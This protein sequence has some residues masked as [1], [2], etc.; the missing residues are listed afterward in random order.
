MSTLTNPMFA[1]NL[2][3]AMLP[4]LWRRRMRLSEDEMVSMYGL[5]QHALHAYHPPELHALREDK[6]ELVAQF[7]YSK[8]L[9]LE[10]DRADSHARP[11]SAPSTIYAICAYFRRYLIDCLRS[12]VHQRHVSIE[13]EGIEQEVNMHAH[14]VEDPIEFVLMQYALDES[15]VR[16]AAAA[17]IAGLDD[18][19]RV[20][21]GGSLGWCSGRKGG[22]SGVAAMHRVSSHHYRAVKLG[23]T[24]RKTATSADF[25]QSKIGR[26]LSDKLGIAISVDNRAAILIVLNLLAE[27]SNEVTSR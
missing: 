10:P 8:V 20:I 9:R 7:I 15:R 12:A 4:D 3:V 11:E 2:D 14:A 13:A 23:V 1:R 17:F 21:L 26:W 25:A 19:D 22:L 18:A 24:V 5:V 6:D 27:E 16:R